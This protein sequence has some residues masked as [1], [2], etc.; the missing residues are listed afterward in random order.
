[1]IDTKNPPTFETITPNGPFYVNRNLITTLLNVRSE[2]II[3]ITSSGIVDFGGAV[4]GVGAPKLDANGD[5]AKT[6][7][8]YPA[9]NLRK[10]SLIVKIGDKWSSIFF[11]TCNPISSK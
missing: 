5:S 3:K 1:M 8:N 2:D 7:S 11:Y 10:N 4:L 6:P 9:P